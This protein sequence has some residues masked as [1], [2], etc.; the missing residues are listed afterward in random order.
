[1]G[2]LP[3]ASV[4]QLNTKGTVVMNDTL[5]SIV[6]LRALRERVE[7]QMSLTKKGVVR[8]KFVRYVALLD[9]RIAIMA[10]VLNG[11]DNPTS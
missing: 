2:F 6:R 8:N 7:V 9:Q 3:I 11:T 4:A 1:M 5:S 10:G